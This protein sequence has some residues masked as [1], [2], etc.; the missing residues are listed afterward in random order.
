[1]LSDARELAGDDQVE[2][3]VCIIGA[4]PAGITIARELI[5]NGARVWLLDSG[6]K[7]MERRAQRLNR[8]QSV[9][10]PIHRL[11]QS[12]VRAFGGTTRH[13]VVPGDETW[14]ARPLDPI[15][16]EVR[17]GIRHSGWPFDR[18]HLD[19]YYAQAQTLCR[20]GPFDY[21]PGRWA[22]PTRHATLAP[23]AG[24][25]RDHAVP[26]RHRRLRGLLRGARP[27]AQRDAAAAR[28]CRRPG[29]RGGPR[30]GGPGRG[31][32]R[33]RL[34]LLRAGT[35]GGAG[36]RRDREPAPAAAQPPGP[37]PRARQR[38]RPGR[39]GSSPSGCRPA[40]G[41]SSRPLPN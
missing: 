22:D 34:A 29:D 19:P 7:D 1:M 21:N 38:S 13:W 37:P 32:A 6:G 12:R 2:V 3:D 10:Y 18:A 23:A 35:A 9:G 27:R 14:A 40:P 28:L 31:P 36:R 41:T 39:D 24:R 8:G 5:G 17:P 4:G 15:D 20:L 33:R 30:P 26:A 11:H 25:G 16:F